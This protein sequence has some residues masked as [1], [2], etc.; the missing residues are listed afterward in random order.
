MLLGLVTLAVF[1][2]VEVALI[3]TI[4]VSLCPVQ[5]HPKGQS[6]SP[7]KSSP[8][9]DSETADLPERKR[10]P[11]I[12]RRHHRGCPAGCGLAASVRR[13]VEEERQ[14]NW[15]QLGPYFFHRGTSA[16]GYV[17]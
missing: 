6:L 10:D 12:S 11:D 8:S 13:T 7:V 9:T 2:G 4:R 5:L 16:R 3:L 17:V 14:G 1:G 15:Y